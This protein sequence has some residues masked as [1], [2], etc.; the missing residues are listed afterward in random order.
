MRRGRAVTGALAY[1]SGLSAEALVERA[2]AERG[3]P[4]V[5]RRWRGSGGEID[6]IA[7][8]GAGL[9]FVEVKKGRSH[10]GAIARLSVRQ[11]AR[12]AASASEYLAGEPEGQ[13]TEVRFDVATVDGQG[14]VRI[15]ENAFDAG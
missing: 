9:I 3:C 15:V 5:A 13:L 7:R 4:A 11:M 10:D 2:Y 6:L 1:R 14:T 12:I 8:D